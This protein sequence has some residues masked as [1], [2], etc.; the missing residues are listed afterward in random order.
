MK[1]TTQRLLVFH[2]LDH[3]IDNNNRG[4]G[5]GQG[6]DNVFEGSNIWG[7]RWR[8][9]RCDDGPYELYT[10]TEALAEDDD[11]G[12]LTTTNEASIEEAEDTTH[13]SELLRRRRHLCVYGQPKVLTATTEASIEEATD[14]TRLSECLQPRRRWCVYGIRVLTTITAALAE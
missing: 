1:S 9:L 3:G 6:I 5:G 11:P 13:L 4:V 12:V 8:M 10:T 7:R 2:Y 14:T